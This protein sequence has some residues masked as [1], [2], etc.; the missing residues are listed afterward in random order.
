MFNIT[1]KAISQLPHTR[2]GPAESEPWSHVVVPEKDVPGLGMAMLELLRTV[3]I[4][5]ALPGCPHSHSRWRRAERHF[6]GGAD[7]L[8]RLMLCESL[9]LTE[10]W[11]LKAKQFLI[12]GTAGRAEQLRL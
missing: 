5:C 9:Q 12:C 10:T 6:P 1:T 3:F 11:D 7:Q 2:A 4:L 8:Q